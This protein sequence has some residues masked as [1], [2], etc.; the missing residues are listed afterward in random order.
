MAELY[1]GF[2]KKITEKFN[3]EYLEIDYATKRESYKGTKEERAIAL[4]RIFLEV[5]NEYYS[6]ND[7]QI[8][9]LATIP[10]AV[11]LAK[12]RKEIEKSPYTISIYEDGTPVVLSIEEFYKT[13]QKDLPQET[14]ASFVEM[15]G[16]ARMVSVKDDTAVLAEYIKGLNRKETASKQ[17]LERPKTISTLHAA[18]PEVMTDFTPLAAIF[19]G[20]SGH[21]YGVH[22]TDRSFGRPGSYYAKKGIKRYAKNEYR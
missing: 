13:F 1:V 10:N 5:A 15:L 11:N 14:R 6:K 20:K 4:R 3:S 2:I 19:S 21:A 8:A 18:K 16:K 9:S 17:V 12:D 22:T 7:F